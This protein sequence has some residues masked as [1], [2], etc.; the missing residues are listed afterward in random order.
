MNASAMDRTSHQSGQGRPIAPDGREG[1]VLSLASEVLRISGG[2]R[3]AA[4]GASMVPT[5]YPGDIL[6]VRREAAR[7]VRCGDV[8]LSFRA[9]RFCAHRLVK[10]LEQDGRVSV[11][12]RGDALRENDPPLAESELLG[13]IT[14]AVRGRKRIELGGRPTA[15]EFLLR[16]AARRSNGL[17]KWLVRW[18]TWPARL[19]RNA[20]RALAEAG[21]Q[22]RECV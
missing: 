8:V 14:A 9:G 19:A 18:H 13:R 11:I 1:V 17:V 15:R 16:C 10:K 5:I 20:D 12:T 21:P 6:I 7:E 22:Q 2:L 3:F 4:L